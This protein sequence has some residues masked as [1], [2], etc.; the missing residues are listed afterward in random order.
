MN[1]RAD[2]ENAGRERFS[3]LIE[4]GFEAAKTVSDNWSS[5]LCFCN[6][7][8]DLSI[9]LHFDWRDMVASVLIVRLTNGREPQGYY[10]SEGKRCR[11]YLQE[12]VRRNKWSVPNASWNRIAPGNESKKRRTSSLSDVKEALESYEEVLRACIENIIMERRS[13]FGLDD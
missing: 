13:L 2:L 6:T 5:T 4:M 1:E 3:F 12:L 9:E 11:V 7:S 10:V 8:V